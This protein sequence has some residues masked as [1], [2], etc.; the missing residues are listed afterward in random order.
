MK[1]FLPLLLAALCLVRSSGMASAQNCA[2]GQC[3]APQSS[4]RFPV[5]YLSAGVYT[6]VQQSAPGQ[7]VDGS[8]T[9]IAHAGFHPIRN[10]IGRLRGAVIT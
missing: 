2:N 10:L 5:T 3:Q 8:G 7:W 4:Y 1:K 6:P 9:G